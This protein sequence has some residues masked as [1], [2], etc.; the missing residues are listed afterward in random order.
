LKSDMLCSSSVLLH[1]MT[2]PG[3]GRTIGI[4]FPP[5]MGTLTSPHSLQHRQDCVF[6]KSV[7]HTDGQSE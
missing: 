7:L 4:W 1:D 6:L 2:R 5:V 3:K